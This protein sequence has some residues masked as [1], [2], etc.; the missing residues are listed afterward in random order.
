MLKP[1]IHNLRGF[2]EAEAKKF[3]DAAYLMAE[4]VNLEEFKHRVFT[5]DY[6]DTGRFK[7][8]G[9][10][11]NVQIYDKLMSGADDFNWSNDGDVDIDATLYF[12]QGNVVGYTYSSSWRTYVNKKFFFKWPIS[13]IAG[14][15]LH[16]YLHNLGYNHS[17]QY[18]DTIRWTVP[19]K[20]ADILVD[21]ASELEAPSKNSPK[22]PN[23]KLV[24]TGWWCFRKC[25]WEY[26]DV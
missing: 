23:K 20:C 15:I 10:D 5:V 14:N 9:G 8:H 22:P 4:A 3:K 17:S 21:L 2:T 13:R 1:H 25:H 16:E 24:C 6:E 12:D 18:N 26:T 11:T 7:M 19:Y